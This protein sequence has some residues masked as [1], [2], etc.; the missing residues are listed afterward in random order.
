MPTEAELYD[1]AL[2]H[3]AENDLEAAVNAFKKLI[4][5]YPD[6]I[7]GFLGLGHAYERMSLYDEAI[8]AIEKAIEIDP[9]DPACI[10]QSIYVLP[11]QRDDPRS[12]RRDGKVAGV[13]DGS[14]P[15]IYM[16]SE[17]SGEVPNL[18]FKRILRF[19]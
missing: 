11:T 6:Y 9:K 12:R 8:E 18:A 15:F 2:T 4:E 1:A 17:R 14:V 16:M 10:Y 19:S 13:A 7:E 3:F 5:T